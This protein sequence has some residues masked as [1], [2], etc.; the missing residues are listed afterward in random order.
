MEC[1]SPKRVPLKGFSIAEEASS[2]VA[3]FWVAA[4]G[5][6]VQKGG[7]EGAVALGLVLCADIGI[8]SQIC[9]FQLIQG[10][11]SFPVPQRERSFPQGLRECNQH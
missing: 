1:G 3:T 2:R 11:F 8:Q 10:L 9:D 7:L 5:G 6:L 4:A